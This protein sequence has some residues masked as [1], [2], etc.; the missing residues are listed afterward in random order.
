MTRQRMA[1]QTTDQS[2]GRS[3]RTRESPAIP[4]ISTMPSRASNRT[5]PSDCQTSHSAIVASD[6]LS[7][8]SPAEPNAA[9]AAPIWSSL[10]HSWLIHG[11]SCVNE[12]RINAGQ[13]MRAEDVETKPH[14]APE[15]RIGDGERRGREDERECR[16]GQPG[17]RP[18]DG[19]HLSARFG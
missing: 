4:A 13:V 18:R 14:V 17:K 6:P 9:Q 10:S 8:D 1:R 15:I 3:V 19:S 2:C 7:R 16:E 11:T 5:S 12:Y